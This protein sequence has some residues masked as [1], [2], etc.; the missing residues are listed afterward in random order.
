MEEEKELSFPSRS[1]RVLH[2]RDT[3]RDSGHWQVATGALDD[4]VIQGE[5]LVIC[6]LIGPA[7]LSPDHNQQ[8][9]LEGLYS[10]Q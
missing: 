6:R 9:R 8:G 7:S 2:S 3:G 4:Y 5:I 1:H 10:V